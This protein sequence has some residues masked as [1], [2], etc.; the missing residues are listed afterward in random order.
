[1]HQLITFKILKKQVLN[2]R[3]SPGLFLKK[4]KQSFTINPGDCDDGQEKFNCFTFTLQLPAF[5]K[6]PNWNVNISLQL[7]KKWRNSKLI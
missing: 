4:M 5:T 1:M 7:S 3:E 2:I 6:Q